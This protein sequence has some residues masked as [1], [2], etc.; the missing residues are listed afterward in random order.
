MAAG[1]R[2]LLSNF[3][4]IMGEKKMHEVMVMSDAVSR[5]AATLDLG[6]VVDLGS[7]KGYLSGMLASMPPCG[8]RERLRILAVDSQ[9]GNTEG[10]KKRSKN[11]EVGKA[12]D[13]DRCSS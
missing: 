3:D 1:N 10:A 2:E 8:G 6:N 5:M 4:R 11:L 12:I 7:G 13:F 9:A